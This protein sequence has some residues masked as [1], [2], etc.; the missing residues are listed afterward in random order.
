LPDLFLY[1]DLYA[2]ERIISL[3]ILA[4]R[5]IGKEIQPTSVLKEKSDLRQ[6]WEK[7]E[8]KTEL[9]WEHTKEAVQDA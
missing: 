8:H 6:G 4:T 5:L 3:Y 1:K 7:L 2:K 9:T